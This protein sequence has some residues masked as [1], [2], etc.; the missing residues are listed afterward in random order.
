MSKQP[1][2]SSLGAK[3]RKPKTHSVRSLRIPAGIVLLIGLALRY[4]LAGGSKA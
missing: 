2:H 4:I 3:A 1:Q